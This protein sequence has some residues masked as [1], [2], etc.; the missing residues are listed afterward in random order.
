L[1]DI[2]FEGS[3]TRGADRWEN[4]AEDDVD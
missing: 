1:G 3:L 4:K 2:V